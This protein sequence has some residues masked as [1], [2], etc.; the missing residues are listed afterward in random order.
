MQTD[1]A[2]EVARLRRQVDILTGSVDALTILLAEAIGALFEDKGDPVRSQTAIESLRA[3]ESAA[4]AVREEDLI[5]TP[6]AYLEGY[7]V[8]AEQV[9]AALG[10][11]ETILR[12]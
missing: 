6:A 11:N 9:D 8:V 10:R 1:D 3:W 4:Q 7:R 5:G 2:E 12:C